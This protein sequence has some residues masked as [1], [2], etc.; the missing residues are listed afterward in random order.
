MDVELQF[1]QYPSHCH[2]WVMQG[3]ERGI[4]FLT[5]IG[6]MLVVSAHVVS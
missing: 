1:H 3:R 2:S 6:L 4:R 5:W